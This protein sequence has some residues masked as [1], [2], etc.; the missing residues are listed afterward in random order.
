M[1]GSTGQRRPIAAAK[2]ALKNVFDKRT[3][4]QGEVE[5]G[6][7]FPI[8]ALKTITR[9][10]LALADPTLLRLIAAAHRTRIE[11]AISGNDLTE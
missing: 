8:D 2:A 1:R 3:V 6:G 4:E 7:E 5:Y 10:H 9:T 11:D